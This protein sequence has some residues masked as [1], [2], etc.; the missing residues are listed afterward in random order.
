[1]K[2]LIFIGILTIIL[3]VNRCNGQNIKNNLDEITGINWFHSYEEDEGDVKTY[4]PESYSFPPSRGRTGFRFKENGSY[5][6]YIIA[7]TDGIDSIKGSWDLYGATSVKITLKDKKPQYA[8][9]K[10]AYL[11][12]IVSMSNDIIKI[13]RHK[14]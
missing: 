4:R 11:L 10:A 5:I 8:E 14:L 12:E 3:S 13:K 2:N 7:P 9:N 1:M 6:E